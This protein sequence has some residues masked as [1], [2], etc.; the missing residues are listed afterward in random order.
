MGARSGCSKPAL[1]REPRPQAR[2]QLSHQLS[3]QL[4]HQLGPSQAS[5]STALDRKPEVRVR[6]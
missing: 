5:T 4:S 1:R 6:A 3:Q 2:P